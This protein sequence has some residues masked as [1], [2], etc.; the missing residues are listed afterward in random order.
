MNKSIWVIFS[1]LLISSCAT[2]NHQY[3]EAHPQA[4]KVNLALKNY[5]QLANEPWP[6]IEIKTPLKPQSNNNQLPQL[7]HRLV[8]L[9]D[10][11]KYCQTQ[12]T[13]F[14]D[15]CLKNAIKHFQA[16]HGL[17]ADGVIGKNTLDELNLSP[18]IRLATLQESLS[19]WLQ[20][21]GKNAK[22]YLQVNIPSYDLKAINKGKTELKMRVV[23]GQA[24]WP[25]PTLN[26][27]IKTVVLNPGWN[28]PVNITEREII[29]KI[30]EN[31]NY[32]EEHNL[33]IVANWNTNAPEINPAT[34]DWRKY[35]GPKDLP[36][37]LV[38]SPGK[39]SALGKI[40]F[41][42]PNKE[43]VYLHDTPQKS[44]FDLTNRN[45]SHGCVRLQKPTELLNYLGATN[46][47]LSQNKIEPYL[48][49]EKT[50]YIALNKNIPLHIT[51]IRAWVDD[52]GQVQFRRDI[53]KQKNSGT[54]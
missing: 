38:Q 49:S 5:R 45:L 14:Y 28:V 52:N 36:Y 41:I 27:E 23:V 34:I 48:N 30:L 15:N 6:Q 25:T 42:F 2:L 32:L 31:P 51:Y 33:K 1:C 11:P 7:K 8:L 3:Q 13:P 16:R 37:R 39:D 24:N 21:P 29:H 47:N 19:K 53:Y 43:H 54:T 10:W 44:S 50:K 12:N 20:L 18:K 9:K 46:A 17:K 26:S 4:Q 40:K 22:A 35:A